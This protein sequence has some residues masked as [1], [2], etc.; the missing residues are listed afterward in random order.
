MDP[1]FLKLISSYRKHSESLITIDKPHSG[2]V[3]QFEM[4]INVMQRHRDDLIEREGLEMGC[5]WTRRSGKGLR[6]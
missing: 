4:V 1:G 2:E 5:S 3:R 6:L